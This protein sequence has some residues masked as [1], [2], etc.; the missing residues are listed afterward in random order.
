[1]LSF[2]HLFIALFLLL[3]NQVW[4][5]SCPPTLDFKKRE[6]ASDNIVDLCEAYRGKVVLIVNTASRCAYTPQYEGLENLYG[7]YKDDGFVVLGFPSN[8][9]G[10]QEPDGEGQVKNFCRLTYGVRFPMFEKV[11]AK[12]DRADPLYQKLA[13]LSGSFPKWNFHKYLIARDGRLVDH[14]P[15]A[16]KPQSHRLVANIEALLAESL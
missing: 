3:S 9:F 4:A 6:L 10:G 13:E 5:T 8:D 11:H 14:Y 2:Q 1:M 12:R 16:T 7:R 15:S